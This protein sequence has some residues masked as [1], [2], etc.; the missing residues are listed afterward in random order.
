MP[1]QGL[2][3]T[4]VTSNTVPLKIHVISLG[5]TCE[6]FPPISTPSKCTDR[7]SLKSNGPR[8]LPRLVSP[9][10][11]R[12]VCHWLS[13]PEDRNCLISEPLEP[14]TGRVSGNITEGAR[15]PQHWK[16]LCCPEKPS[17]DIIFRSLPE[18]PARSV[19]LS[20]LNL[21]ELVNGMLRRALKGSPFLKV[22]SRP[23]FVSYQLP[24]STLCDLDRSRLYVPASLCSEADSAVLPNTDEMKNIDEM[25]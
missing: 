4:V 19:D 17:S 16:C 11:H 2:L 21:T 22:Q 18:L 15:L 3:T 23:I 12:E 5:I 10:T 7:K 1:S 24:F 14:R 8:T 6:Y 9:L 20:A 13:P 25:L